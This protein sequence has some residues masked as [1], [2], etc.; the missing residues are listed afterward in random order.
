MV[1]KE[2]RDMLGAR[3]GVI[4][5]DGSK[6]W[7]RVRSD[8]SYG[9]ANDPRVLVGLGRSVEKPKVHVSDLA[10]V[11]VY[12][13]DDSI[14]Q[15]AATL[16]PSRRGEYE[17]TEA[18]QWLI[19]H[20]KTVRAEMVN[21]WWKDTGRPADLLEAN[22]VMLSVL[23]SA[24][25]GGVDEASTL[26]GV[27]AVAPGAQIVRSRIRGPV[28]LTQWAAQP[29]TVFAAFSPEGAYTPAPCVAQEP[30]GVAVGR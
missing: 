22:R 26:E 18:I 7:R 27:V 2:G 1:G 12:L 4:R 21:G 24:V 28:A 16:E 20:G 23:A 29:Q 10:L 6:L 30:F 9:S 19:D 3:V 8:G 15:A 14:L 13:F 5:S 17:I 25:E 11:G